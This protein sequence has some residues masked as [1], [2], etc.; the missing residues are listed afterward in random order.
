MDYIDLI[1]MRIALDWISWR[2]RARELRMESLVYWD[3]VET[4]M[5]QP[6]LRHPRFQ[7]RQQCGP[8]LLLRDTRKASCIRLN[9][10]VPD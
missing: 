1:A 9:L 10:V 7:P 5:A 4:S 2:T 8:K 3:V 6:V